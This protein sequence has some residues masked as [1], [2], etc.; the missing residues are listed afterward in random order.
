M[1]VVDN[2]S[3]VSRRTIALNIDSLVGDEAE[4]WTSN[5][6][7]FISDC[8]HTVWSDRRMRGFLGVTAHWI[9]MKDKSLQL[10]SQ[11]LACNRFKATDVTKVERIVTF[12]VLRYPVS[13]LLIATWKIQKCILWTT[14]TTDEQDQMT[15]AEPESQ[16][17]LFSAY[18]KK[19]RRD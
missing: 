6:K 13:F 19:Q 15:M 3:P 14:P 4:K 11:L 7:Y 12:E 5:G 8:R 16:S 2:Y 1:S 9:K 10:K 17:G 18:R